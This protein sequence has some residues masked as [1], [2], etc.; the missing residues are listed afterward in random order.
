MITVENNKLN[1]ER[2]SE[3]F[4]QLCKLYYERVIDSIER[5][6]DY[7]RARYYEKT[8]YKNIRDLQSIHQTA[9]KI[10]KEKGIDSTKIIKLNALKES[11]P[12]IFFYFYDEIAEKISPKSSLSE[13]V[14]KEFIKLLR[15]E[16]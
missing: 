2:M 5:Y 11:C 7:Q 12:E 4:H 6:Y 16:D 15:S 1:T 8:V 3:R 10:C 14:K 9:M 13:C